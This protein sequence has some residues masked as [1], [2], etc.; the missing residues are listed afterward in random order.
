LSYL[1]VKDTVGYGYSAFITLI[2]TLNHPFFEQYKVNTDPWPWQSDPVKYKKRSRKTFKR[3][4]INMTLNQGLFLIIALYFGVAPMSFDFDD[5]P[6]YS[7]LLTQFVFCFLFAEFYFYWSH[8][9]A[10]HPRFYWIHKK[11][12]K[13]KNTVVM[14]AQYVSYWE[15]YGIDGPTIGGGILILGLTSSTHFITFFI[16]TTWQLLSNLD[17]HTGYEFPWMFTKQLPWC[18]SNTWHNYHHLF[19]VGNYSAHTIFWDCI[20]GTCKDYSDH[21][22]VME[23]KKTDKGTITQICAHT[24]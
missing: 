4:A 6:S 13:A 22:D 7:K 17:D 14:D 9:L 15:F 11:H 8:R 12:H 16:Y 2:Y 18:A 3:F 19:N 10:H 5:L 23:K 20:F 1:L 21:F 24:L